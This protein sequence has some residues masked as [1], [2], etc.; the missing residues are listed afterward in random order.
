[1]PQSLITKVDRAAKRHD[2]NRSELIRD[3]LRTYLETQQKWEDIFSYGQQQAAER[4][5]TERDVLKAVSTERRKRR[6]RV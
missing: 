5:V 2:A 4:G 3:A 1:L 6:T